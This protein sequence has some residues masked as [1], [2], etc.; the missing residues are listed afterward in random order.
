MQQESQEPAHVFYL[1][2]LMCRTGYWH[3]LDIEYRIHQLSRL[4]VDMRYMLNTRSIKHS[5]M[6]KRSQ[7]VRQVGD[8]QHEMSFLLVQ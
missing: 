2:P 7:A 5:S 3:V 4:Y 6:Q 1:R 8:M